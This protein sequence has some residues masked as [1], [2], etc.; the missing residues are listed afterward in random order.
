MVMYLLVVGGAVLYMHNFAKSAEQVLASSQAAKETESRILEQAGGTETG[1]SR[2][3]RADSAGRQQ[4]GGSRSLG[5][6]GASPGLG[7]GEHRALA[8]MGT[9]GAGGRDEEKG[10]LTVSNSPR[11]RGSSGTGQ[12]I[13]E[14]GLLASYAGQ[15][16][17]GAGI[18]GQQQGQLPSS[19]PGSELRNGL[20]PGNGASAPAGAR[21]EGPNVP[22]SCTPG[23]KGLAA[24]AAAGG[25]V[26]HSSHLSAKEEKARK[27]A[28]LRGALQRPPAAYQPYARLHP[29]FYG[30]L[31]ALVGAQT[32]V[33]AKSVTEIVKTTIRGENQF[34]YWMTYLL[35][36]G[37]GVSIVGQ[38]H[39]MA[40][41]L[42]M[43]DSLLVVPV[44][45]AIFMA[46]TIVSG[47]IYFKEFEGFTAQ[48]AMGFP[49]GVLL[50]LA[51]VYVLSGRQAKAA[52][53]KA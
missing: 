3:G 47:G 13:E 26:P 21:G 43:F 11:R 19:D 45:S 24:G 50:T 48:Q 4:R 31:A 9:S 40:R 34:V 17:H 29:V 1:T 28:V 16:E 27:L 49:C 7:V 8:P 36:A 14:I 12:S 2:K 46:A 22:L 15:S 51:G 6:G 23:N 38:Q 30:T 20:R 33:F 32:V 53:G 35:I 5:N 37:T 52:S 10:T 18:A 41:G 25:P 42:Q 44:F 39:Y